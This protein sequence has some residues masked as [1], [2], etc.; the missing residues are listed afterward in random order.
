[1]P[2]IHLTKINN[3][4]IQG[5]GKLNFQNSM[6]QR[7]IG[8][9]K[10]AERFKEEVQMGKTTRRNAAHPGHK[11]NGKKTL[12]RFHLAAIE[13]PSS[14]PRLSFLNPH[15]PFRKHHKMICPSC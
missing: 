4:N 10:R 9:R 3:Q 14:R 6:T 11:G 12:L 7:R 5:L 1:L 2:A 13:W 15:S 8:Q